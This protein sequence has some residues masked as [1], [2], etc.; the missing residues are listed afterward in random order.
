MKQIKQISIDEIEKQVDIKSEYKKIYKVIQKGEI[1]I[2]QISKET[3]MNIGELNSK[4][5]M[6]E[7]ERTY[8]KQ[9]R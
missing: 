7:L 8:R 3:K 5:L 4:L 6:M 9:T 2:N 1:H